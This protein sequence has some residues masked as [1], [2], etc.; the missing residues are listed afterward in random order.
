[1]IFLYFKFQS[2]D[3][4]SIKQFRLREDI[5]RNGGYFFLTPNGKG[6]AFSYCYAVLE[7]P[8]IQKTIDKELSPEYISRDEFMQ[9]Y[10]HWGVKFDSLHPSVNVSES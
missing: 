7:K 6:G 1:M 9:A 2:T 10:N 5:D 8:E 3:R 4:E